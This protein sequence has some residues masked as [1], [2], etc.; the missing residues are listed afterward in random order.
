MEYRK[1]NENKRVANEDILE[2]VAEELG[3]P[4]DLVREVVDSQFSYTGRVIKMG[5]FENIIIP[6]LGKFK[7]NIRRISKAMENKGKAK[8]HEI[9]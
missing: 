1:I 8:N 9:I 4:P 3:L 5:N 6:Y 7:P 2:E